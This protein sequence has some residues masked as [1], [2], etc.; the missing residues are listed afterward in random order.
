M[1]TKETGRQEEALSQATV[2]AEEASRYPGAAFGSVA[3]SPEVRAP[4]SCQSSPP[5]EK[6]EEMSA[7][8]QRG[9]RS[10]RLRGI[11]CQ[12]NL[13]ASGTEWDLL[14]GTVHAE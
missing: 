14:R 10:Q 11:W 1:N 12:A 9:Q 4:V 6:L 5:A 2:R 3:R 8:P 13:P 7:T